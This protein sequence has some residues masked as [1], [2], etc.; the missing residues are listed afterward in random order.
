MVLF[1]KYG[2]VALGTALAGLTAKMAAGRSSGPGPTASAW[3][4][5]N[6]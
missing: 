4:F 3:S 2:V 6:G 1:Y 5:P